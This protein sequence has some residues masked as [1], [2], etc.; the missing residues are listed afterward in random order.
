MLAGV[1]DDPP[2]SRNKSIQKIA[3]VSEIFYDYMCSD[4]V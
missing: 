2:Q 1:H 3:G 4:G